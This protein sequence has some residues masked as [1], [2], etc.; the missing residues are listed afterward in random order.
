[1]KCLDCGMDSSD[2]RPCPAHPVNERLGYLMGTGETIHPA[3]FH[4]Y[5]A[6]LMKVNDVTQRAARLLAKYLV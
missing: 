4:A 1:M 6:K 5:P 2:P 3:G